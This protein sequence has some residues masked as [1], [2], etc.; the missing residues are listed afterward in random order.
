MTNHTKKMIAASLAASSVTATAIAAAVSRKDRDL[1]TA[2]FT[3]V[4]A[5]GLVGAALLYRSILKDNSG[6]HKKGR[7]RRFLDVS[8][9]FEDGEDYRGFT[10]TDDSG[11]LHECPLY[12]M[13]TEEEEL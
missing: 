13:K 12:E 1:M 3:S 7:I 5:E 4:A 2:V 11:R 10:I 8:S 6:I 9:L